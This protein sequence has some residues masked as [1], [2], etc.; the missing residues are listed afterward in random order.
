MSEAIKKEMCCFGT[1]K[2][3]SFPQKLYEPSKIGALMAEE[4][5]FRSLLISQLR[6]KY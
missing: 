4:T 2:E 5:S 3:Q 6:T 1:L